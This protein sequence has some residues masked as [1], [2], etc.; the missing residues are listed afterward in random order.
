MKIN[1]KFPGT[2]AATGRQFSR[3]DLIEFDP[4]TKRVVLL[5]KVTKPQF[6]GRQGHCFN[7]RRFTDYYIARFG[8]ETTIA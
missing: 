7:D 4:R 6:Q 5:E 1:A 3:G 2:C 8:N